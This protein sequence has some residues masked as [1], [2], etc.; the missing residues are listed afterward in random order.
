M[1][2]YNELTAFL[3][4]ADPSSPD[5]Y[6]EIDQRMD[7]HGMIDY[8]IAQFYFGNVDWPVSNIEFWRITADT[9]KWRVFFYDSDASMVWLNF[10][11]IADYGQ[12]MDDYQKFPEFSTFMLRSLLRNNR[13][14]EEFSQKYYGHLSAT[15]SADHVIKMINYFEKIYA[16]LVPEHIYRWNNPVDYTKWMENV[17]WLK[18]F[19]LRRPMIVAEQLQNNFGNPFTVY[20]NPC[21]G[22]F[23]ADFFSNVK[24]AT[25][26]VF[27]VNGELLKQWQVPQN[28]DGPVWFHSGLP[29]GLYFLQMV[30]YDMSFI[31]KLIIQ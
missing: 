19:A 21:D 11:P 18:E 2:A 10:D 3:Q 13:F 5:F 14:R 29:P 8:F 31:G 30:I 28:Q 15:F 27:S 12:D 4:Y 22:D 9:A 7:I 17:D 24:P 1:D 26:K 25:I 6:G 20:P 16:P 23:S